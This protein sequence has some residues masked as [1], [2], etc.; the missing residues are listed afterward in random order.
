MSTATGIEAYPLCWPTDWPRHGGDRERARFN[1]KVKT[2]SG[3]T[4][5][6]FY[7]RSQ[8]LSIADATA[9]VVSEL[10]Q[11]GVLDGAAIISSNIPLRR[12]GLPRSDARSPADPGVAVYWRRPS[13]KT[14][15]VMAIDQ[16]DRV[17]DNLAAIAATLDAMRAIERHGGAQILDRAFTGFAAL[18]PAVH[19]RKGQPWWGI[20]GC[21]Q[22]TATD[23]VLDLYRQLAK[24]RHPDRGGSDELVSELNEA[25]AAFKRERGLI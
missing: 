3:I 8:E 20:F 6:S 5:G 19:D 10:R 22:T 15:K 13:D 4:P 9:R 2:A 18:P 21:Q 17:Q 23:A 1:R 12:D 25:Y 14:E 16:Y 7:R 11:F 24:E